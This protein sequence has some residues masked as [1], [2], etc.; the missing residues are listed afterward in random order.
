MTHARFRNRAV[1]LVAVLLIGSAGAPARAQADASDTGLKKI[2]VLIASLKSDIASIKT[3]VADLK[4]GK[5]EIVKLQTNVANIKAE[6]ADLKTRGAGGHDAKPR[7]AGASVKMTGIFAYQTGELDEFLTALKKWGWHIEKVESDSSGGGTITAT[8]PLD[9]TSPPSSGGHDAS[10]TAA[11]AA[12]G[13]PTTTAAVAT[14]YTC[15]PVY[16][17]QAQTPLLRRLCCQ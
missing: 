15:Y 13:T 16:V 10:G 5:P 12:T 6:V 3:D 7:A 4:A 1:T 2:E 17:I 9:A 14:Q 8:K 11:M